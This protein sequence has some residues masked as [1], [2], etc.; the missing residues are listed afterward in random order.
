MIK[1]I[2]TENFF[3]G[4]KIMQSYTPHKSRIALYLPPVCC[5]SLKLLPVANMTT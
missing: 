3:T 4:L 1:F 2:I 5:L